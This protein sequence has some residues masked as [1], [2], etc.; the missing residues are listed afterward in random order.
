[1]RNYFVRCC[2]WQMRCRPRKP[3]RLSDTQYNQ[4]RPGSRGNFQNFVGWIALFYQIFRTHQS[5]ASAGT[6][7]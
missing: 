7:L 5:S 2:D 1:M 3:A 6:R 4:L